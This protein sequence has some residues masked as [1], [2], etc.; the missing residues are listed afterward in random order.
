MGKTKL[1][2]HFSECLSTRKQI[3]HE[4]LS[5]S[6]YTEKVASVQPKYIISL[7]ILLMYIYSCS[8]HPEPCPE[9]VQETIAT[10]LAYRQKNLGSNL[11]CISY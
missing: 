3:T 6:D 9:T 4:V 2:T 8:Y 11:K 1:Y 5:R 7:H 10:Y